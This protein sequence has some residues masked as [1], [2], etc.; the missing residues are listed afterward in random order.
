MKY[1]LVYAKDFRKLERLVNVKIEEGW[2]PLGGNSAASSVY[3]QAM[4]LEDEPVPPMTDAEIAQAEAAAAEAK[5]K[6]TAEKAAA[7]KAANKAAKEAL[8]AEEAADEE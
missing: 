7:T 5:K 4:L 8:L 2:I 1:K 3:T 6:A